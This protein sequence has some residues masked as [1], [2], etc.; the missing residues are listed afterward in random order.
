VKTTAGSHAV[1]ERLKDYLTIHTPATLATYRA[2]IPGASDATFRSSALLLANWYHTPGVAAKPVPQDVTAG[3]LR[4]NGAC[5]S[6]GVSLQVKHTT[7]TTVPCASRDID[8]MCAASPNPAE[9][10]AG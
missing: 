7:T 3:W 6:A 2:A 5:G 9:G 1:C 10:S 8:G 4:V